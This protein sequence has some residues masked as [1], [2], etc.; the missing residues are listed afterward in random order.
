LYTQEVAINNDNNFVGE[1]AQKAVI[2]KNG[3]VLV[4]G[5]P[6]SAGWDLPGG[7]I[8]AGETP[9]DALTREIQEELG[10]A[11]TIERV[12]FADMWMPGPTHSGPGRYFVAFAC[13]LTNPDAPFVLQEEE[14]S[15]VRWIGK[16]EIDTLPVF[17]I[18]KDALRAYFAL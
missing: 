11:V 6:K 2:A 17:S 14:I 5:D 3:K 13:S 16:E 4:V 15:E 18:C 7:R 8:H 9:K 1:V 12:F 10:V